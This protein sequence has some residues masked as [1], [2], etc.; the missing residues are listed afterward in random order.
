M[1]TLAGYYQ[2]QSSASAIM[3]GSGNL[4]PGTDIMLPGTAATLLAPKGHIWVVE[5]LLTFATKAG[6]IP[7]GVTWSNRTELINA[8]EVRG[9]VGFNFDFSTLFAGS[10]STK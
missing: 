2:Y 8:Q 3:I 10:Q 6:N 4:A 7:V 5:G 1:G 9:H